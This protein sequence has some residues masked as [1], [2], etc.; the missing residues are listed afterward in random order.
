[1][2]EVSVVAET[3]EVV[4][5]TARQN[6]KYAQ[7]SLAK[8]L[9]ATVGRSG[10]TEQEKVDRLAAAL[11]STL[12]AAQ[13]LDKALQQAKAENDGQIVVLEYVTDAEAQAGVATQADEDSEALATA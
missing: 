5:Y 13:A 2:T 1:M 9:N 6:R 12:K 11:E 8:A 10:L 7:K 3:A 4:E